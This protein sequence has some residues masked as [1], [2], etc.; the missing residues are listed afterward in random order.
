MRAARRD[1]ILRMPGGWGH[2]WAG[3][4]ASGREARMEGAVAA[5]DYGA[6]TRHAEH[7]GV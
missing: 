7:M 5:I 2:L 1:E 4:D 6:Q 3:G